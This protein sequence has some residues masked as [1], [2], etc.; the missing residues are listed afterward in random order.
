M[1]TKLA[2]TKILTRTELY[3]IF[4]INV[5]RF[6]KDKRAK[7]RAVLL[8]VAY[9]FLAVMMMFYVG[10]FS[11]ALGLLSLSEAVPSYLIAISSFFLFFLGIL[12]A[13]GVVFRKEGYDI[14]SS[15]PLAQGPIV[16]SRFLRL[17]IEDLPFALAVLLPGL[18]VY[19]YMVKPGGAF[20]LFG[21]W[22]V[23]LV[24]VLPI[25]GAV[26][27]SALVMAIASR[28]RYKSIAVSG[29]SILVVLAIMAGTSRLSTAGE[30]SPEMWRD[31]SGTV[32]A[33]LEKVYPPAVFLGRAVVD[34]D[35]GKLLLGTALFALAFVTVAV[36]VSSCFHRIC[37]SLYGTSAKH[38]YQM[39]EMKRSFVL[40]ALV[41]R[42]L[43]RYFSSGA[44][45]ANTII[46][47]V[48]AVVF[49]G[50]ALVTGTDRLAEFLP[51]PVDIGGFI[52]FVLA[53]IFSMMNAT[54]VSVSLEGKQWW[55]I[56]S[57]PLS[58]KPI[59]DA[60]I[61]MNMILVLPFYLVSEVMLVLAVRPGLPELIWL[62]LIPAEAIL[63]SSVFGLSVNLRFPV[64]TWESETSVVKQS[65]SSLLGGLGGILPVILFGGVAV[66]AGGGKLHVVKA[67]GS[68]VILL[69]TVLLYQ[70]NCRTD[71]K[72][73]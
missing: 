45:I 63:F 40:S 44:Y 39:G 55:I 42:E 24:P 23:L 65:V 33:V 62:I 29:L 11:F 46:G 43:K 21:F 13:G 7:R 31:L 9:G 71:L 4:G 70:K 32:F 38:N 60:K 12:K 16:A 35:F 20:F 10:G 54:C 6:S 72:E 22:A 47:P 69:I 30:F 66:T 61:L 8:L 50:A 18:S 53:G 36:F 57:L 2:Q 5:L 67:I 41:R 58:P 59:L 25:V 27:V 52:P 49:A 1:G 19:A 28:M 56:N 14:L 34:M 17:Y 3:N 48:M 73:L 51:I 15:L 37:R 64:F 68:V 26:F